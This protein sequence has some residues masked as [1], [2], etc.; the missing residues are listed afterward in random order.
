[1]DALS[2]SDGV[3]VHFDAAGGHTP[4]S[5]EIRPTIVQLDRPVFQYSYQVSD[6]IR[7]NGDGLLQRGEQITIFLKVKN[8]GTGRSYE[9]QANLANRSGDGV[10]LR[11]GRFDIS[12]MLPGDE[13]RVAFTFDVQRQLADNEVV[14]LL[15]VTDRDLREAASE[16]LKLP[17][18]GAVKVTEAKSAVTTTAVT[19][20]FG[21]VIGS[22]EAFGKLA[23][24][25]AL[26]QLGRRGNMARVQ[27]TP[28]RFAFVRSAD[29][30]A[31]GTPQDEVAF[32]TIYGHAPPILTVQAAAAATR[33]DT[34]KIQVDAYD[35]ERLLDM[36]M[37]VGPRKLYYQSNRQGADPHRA[38]F[39]FD[40]PLQPGV[41]LITVVARE[42]ADTTT[43]RV[44]VVR[45]D[46]ADGTILKTP[47]RQDNYLLE[48]LK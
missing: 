37:F 4:A 45:R 8:V 24:G 31:G 18:T 3:K 5:V 27:L 23:K 7:G 17:V 10:L 33:A 41:N 42:S 36:Y 29:L 26:Q 22:R 40:A 9:T 46:A 30:Q 39:E 28:S 20:L 44:V 12:N 25:T 35:A 2:R 38:K 47:K 34:V 13:R 48:A 1:M 16:K 19:Q 6:N 43:R 32:D 21:D 11:A 14:L 15:S